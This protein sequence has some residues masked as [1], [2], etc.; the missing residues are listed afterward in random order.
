MKK[1]S[2]SKVKEPFPCF[3]ISVSKQ[4][5]TCA[6][7]S[8]RSKQFKEGKDYS[9]SERFWET[10]NHLAPGEHISWPLSLGRHVHLL[11]AGEEIPLAFPSQCLFLDLYT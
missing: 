4:P 7:L 8:P 9:L 2:L 6:Q 10:L 3:Q 1:S 5:A 11:G